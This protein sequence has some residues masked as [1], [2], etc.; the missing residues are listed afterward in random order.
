MSEPQEPF[1]DKPSDPPGSRRVTAFSLTREDLTLLLQLPVGY[2]VA[3]VRP[4][5]PWE[6]PDQAL[7]VL[8]EG[9]NMPLCYRNSNVHVECPDRL[10]IDTRQGT[11]EGIAW[12]G[13]VFAQPRIE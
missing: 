2:R 11:L 1:D 5:T 4:P 12:F 13:M 7:M 6:H 10:V 3:E 9:P 8:V